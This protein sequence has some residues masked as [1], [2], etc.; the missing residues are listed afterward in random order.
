MIKLGKVDAQGGEVNVYSNFE[1]YG[2]T[3]RLT[4][5]VRMDMHLNA[6]RPGLEEASKG[7][8]ALKHV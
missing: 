6:I 2:L 4:G 8:F 5:L 3:S 7:L 1:Q